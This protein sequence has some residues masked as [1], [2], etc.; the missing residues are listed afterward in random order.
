LD[1]SFQ[2]A[3]G[4]GFDNYVYAL[5]VATYPFASRIIAGGAF[6][7]FNGS[8]CNSIT[9]L[10]SSGSLDLSFNAAIGSGFNGPVACVI[11]QPN[12]GKILVGGAF[13]QF[14]GQTCNFIARLNTNGTLDTSFTS[15]SG[16]NNKVTCIAIQ[17]HTPYQIIVGGSFTMYNGLVCNSI[18]RLNASN[19]SLDTSFNTRAGFISYKNG[20]RSVAVQAGIYNY[21]V[22]VGGDFIKFNKVLCNSIA[23]IYWR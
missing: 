9:R 23:R 7:H 2:T 21:N 5:A 4:S 20:V 17:P 19:G 3:I 11:L 16:F 13:T 8:S 22:F 10:L 1:L 12:D 15:G 18:A 14:N 6:T